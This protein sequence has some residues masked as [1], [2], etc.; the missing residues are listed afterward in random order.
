[1]L[2]DLCMGPDAFNKSRAFLTAK[3]IDKLDFPKFL[4]VYAKYG[5]LAAPSY[6]KLAAKVGVVPIW[7]PSTDG[8]WIE[9]C[10]Y[11]KIFPTVLCVAL[12]FN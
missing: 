2:L 8:V 4:E 5:G 9:V 3:S 11:Y 1:M 7:V 12:V 10:G 6:T